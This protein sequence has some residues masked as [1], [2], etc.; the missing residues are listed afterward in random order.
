MSRFLINVGEKG[1]DSHMHILKKPPVG[2]ET[3]YWRCGHQP[4]VASVAGPKG[5]QLLV[6]AS[7]AHFTDLRLC[8]E[9]LQCALRYKEI[10]QP[11]PWAGSLG[12][13]SD[14]RVLKP[15]ARVPKTCRGW[16]S[17]G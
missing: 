10:R 16:C 8:P 1:R 14:N 15:E 17:P 12:L 2:N 3:L 5:A 13:L 7:L 9:S 11:A 6:F 4:T